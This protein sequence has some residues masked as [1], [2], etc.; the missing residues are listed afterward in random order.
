[1]KVVLAVGDLS[2]NMTLQ[3]VVS[4]D[5]RAG[6]ELI[7]SYFTGLDNEDLTFVLIDCRIGLGLIGLIGTGWL[8]DGR[9]DGRTNQRTDGADLPSDRPTDSD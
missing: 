4:K 7:S 2:R 5:I 9:M 1:M 6:E 3:F 8:T